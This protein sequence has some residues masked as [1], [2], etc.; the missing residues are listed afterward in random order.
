MHFSLAAG[1]THGVVLY[2]TQP[3]QLTGHVNKFRSFLCTLTR[4]TR[5]QAAK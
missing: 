3:E 1:A 2:H 4:V 5:T